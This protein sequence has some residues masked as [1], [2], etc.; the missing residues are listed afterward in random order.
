M[1]FRLKMI[2][3]GAHKTRY[4]NAAEQPK[5]RIVLVD[6]DIIDGKLMQKAL[7]SRRDLT[8]THY[9]SADAAS[10]L[11]Q[12]GGHD[13]LCDV[14]LIDLE[15]PK[16]D[17]FEFLDILRDRVPDYRRPILI[18]YSGCLKSIEPQRLEKFD[19][20]FEKSI[21]IADLNRVMDEVIR[22]VGE[23]RA[24]GG[25]RAK[26]GSKLNSTVIGLSS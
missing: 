26:L 20:A 6:D 17:G 2:P 13:Q 23:R 12:S 10:S 15:M 16:I 1:V 3:G 4:A 14:V 11:W 9:T 21:S 25:Y 22:C 8:I 5:V 24:G 18:A 19:E 7:Q